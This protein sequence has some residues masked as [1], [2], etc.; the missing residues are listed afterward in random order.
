MIKINKCIKCNGFLE[1][2]GSFL[3][4]KTIHCEIFYVM[5]SGGSLAIHIKYNGKKYTM[6]YF[7]NFLHKR[8]NLA[9]V[10]NYSPTNIY[11][12]KYDEFFSYDKVIEII[13]NQVFK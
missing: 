7:D 12:C 9:E 6:I 3:T 4:D 5:M 2:D 11:N 13:N 8:F 10:N 1:L